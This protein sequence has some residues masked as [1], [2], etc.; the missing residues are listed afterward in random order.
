M[1]NTVQKRT[2]VQ[3]LDR[4]VFPWKWGQS[5]G[6][7]SHRLE[8]ERTKTENQKNI[9]NHVMPGL[10]NIRKN[11]N[12][13]LFIIT[14]NHKYFH[15]CNTLVLVCFDKANRMASIIN[16]PPWLWDGL[17]SARATSALPSCV[18][19]PSLPKRRVNILLAIS[20]NEGKNRGS[21]KRLPLKQLRAGE[22]LLLYSENIC[23]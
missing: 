1:N 8:I 15:Y 22:I 23:E 11:S 10:I 2:S 20:T 18:L 12:L 7:V 19:A 5:S 6:V 13:R 9:I 16:T 17:S 4:G 14:L 21:A 3:C